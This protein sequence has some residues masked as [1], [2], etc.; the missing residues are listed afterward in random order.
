MRYVIGIDLGGT[1]IKAASVSESG[2]VLDR[3]TGE[4]R[5][6]AAPGAWVATIRGLRAQIESARREP[7]LAIGVAAPG[8]ATDGFPTDAVAGLQASRRRATIQSPP[9]PN[10]ISP[11][12]WGRNETEK[13]QGVLT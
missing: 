3:V 5:D 4:T 7:A 8:L 9:Q 2:D 10:A 6:H 13:D 1:H 11:K 12:A